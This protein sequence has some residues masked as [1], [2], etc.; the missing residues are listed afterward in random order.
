MSTIYDWEIFADLNATADKEANWKEG[1]RPKIVNDSAR[2]V[3]KR[4]KEYIIDVGGSLVGQV[5]NDVE[6]KTTKITLNT[7]ALFESIPNGLMLR[8]RASNDIIGNAT[9]SVNQILER[10][11]MAVTDSGYASLKAGAIRQNGIYEVVYLEA[12]EGPRLG[13]WHLINPTYVP[14]P[15]TPK[16][17][18]IPTGSI[19]AFA[20]RRVS[21]GWL[22]CN[23]Q[24]VSRTE[25]KDLLDVIGLTFGI[26]DGV[27]T[28]N[29]PDL[30]G[31]FLRGFDAGR[32]IDRN[33]DFG[34]LQHDSIAR[35]SH[36]LRTDPDPTYQFKIERHETVKRFRRDAEDQDEAED[37]EELPPPPPPPPPLPA[38]SP[39]D[40]YIMLNPY[41][42]ALLQ[43]FFKGEHGDPEQRLGALSQLMDHRHTFETL[44]V[45]GIETRPKN[46]SIMF[47]IK[48]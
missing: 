43:E 47:A 48:T 5:V 16:H 20:T 34:S 32:G 15:E 14:P 13:N 1:M 2:V 46:V 23:G 38:P 21:L 8:F 4:V 26:G 28:F 36:S 24:A 22:E 10:P 42:F 7:T 33:R 40:R 29:L 3:M 17:R 41:V 12:D 6:N 30:R 27:N 19:A 44:D 11:V 39:Y 37:V 45:G 31:V 25:Y 18:L 9:L 35:H